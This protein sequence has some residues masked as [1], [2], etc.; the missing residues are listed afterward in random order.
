M[1]PTDLPTNDSRYR[2]W[3]LLAAQEIRDAPE[4]YHDSAGEPIFTSVGE[5]IADELD[6]ETIP[7][8]WWG[9]DAAIDAFDLAYDTDE[10]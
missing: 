7:E 6:M 1:L 8:H 4:H 5:W 2:K 3:V 9:W 10:D